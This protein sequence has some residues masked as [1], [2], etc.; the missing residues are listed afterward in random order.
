MASKLLNVLENIEQ[1]RQ[2]IIHDANLKNYN[3]SEDASFED[4]KD[5][6]SRIPET[7]GMITPITPAP[8]DI[9]ALKRNA[10]TIPIKYRNYKDDF[11]NNSA[12]TDWAPVCMVVLANTQTTITFAVGNKTALP[13]STADQVILGSRS[14]N[15]YYNTY[16]PVNYKVITSDGATYDFIERDNNNYTTKTHTWDASQDVDNERWF[17]VYIQP[18]TDSW[19]TYTQTMEGMCYAIL[20]NSQYTGGFNISQIPIVALYE[21]ES[22]INTAMGLTSN[23]SNKPAKTTYKHYFNTDV[24]DPVTESVRNYII[25]NADITKNCLPY[26]QTITYNN[27][28]SN[29]ETMSSDTELYSNTSGGTFN[30]TTPNYKGYE[31]LKRS[32]KVPTAGYD[33]AFSSGFVVVGPLSTD[34]STADAWSKILYNYTKIKRP[35]VYTSSTSPHRGHQATMFVPIF[36]TRIDAPVPTQIGGTSNVQNLSTNPYTFG[37]HIDLPDTVTTLGCWA[38]LN[39]GAND[40]LLDLDNITTL[41]GSDPLERVMALNVKMNNLTTSTY[42]LFETAFM[43]T[44]QLNGLTSISTNIGS[45]AW[46]LTRLDCPLLEEYMYIFPKSPTIEVINMPSLKRCIERPFNVDDNACWFMN[47]HTLII[48]EDFETSLDLRPLTSLSRTSILD[49]ANKLKDYS[50]DPGTHKLT[51]QKCV[52]EQL[53]TD[54]KAIITDKGW[55]VELRTDIKY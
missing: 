39:A 35:R 40:Y 28:C 10:L 31:V 19:A 41:I 49:I 11:K 21:N 37:G 26:M 46:C 25:N 53:S 9:D 55:L 43:H 13:T 44:L 29:F 30:G 22:F 12:L 15:N 4:I 3:L 5:V 48:G 36:D 14:S 18:C 54:E 51:L 6:F 52:Y 7:T 47:L 32:V 50:S 24:A 2:N 34:V 38:F 45:T 27:V 23:D 1:S 8:I 20:R 42:R 33:A 16:Y 17:K